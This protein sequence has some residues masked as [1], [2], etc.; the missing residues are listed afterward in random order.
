VAGTT[1]FEL[2]IF[3]ND[4][5][6]VDSEPIANRILA[7]LLRS[8]GLEVD[9]HQCVERYLGSTLE[10]VRALVEAELG[11]P[12]PAD[13]EARYRDT[14]YPRLAAEVEAV[15]GVATVL[16]LLARG[17]VVLCVASSG[18]HERIRITLGRA[19]LLDRFGDRLFSA[20]D[21]GVGKP[22]P[23]LFLHAAATLG[24][25]PGRC[26]V[27]EDA[28]AGIEAANAAGMVAFGFTRLTPAHLLV[29]AAGGLFQ[30]MAE[31]PALLAAGDPVLPR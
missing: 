17:D 7:G 3:D 13:F 11:R 18:L 28:P 20:Q 23:D 29:G 8:Y 27:V 9:W 31:L 24:V 26:A 16:D 6:L 19:G 21:V 1:P 14:V 10:R 22:A 4:G 12:I 5:V 30:D 2:I 25:E 15:P